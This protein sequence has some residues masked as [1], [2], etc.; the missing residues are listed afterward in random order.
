MRVLIGLT[1]SRKTNKN[2][3]ESVYFSKQTLFSNM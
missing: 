1:D 2:Q 3:K